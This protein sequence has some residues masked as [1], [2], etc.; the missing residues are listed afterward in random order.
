MRGLSI[1]GLA[2]NGLERIA[3]IARDLP[4]SLISGNMQMEGYTTSFEVLLGTAERATARMQY[5]KTFAAKTPFELPEVVAGSITLQSLTNG[6]LAEGAGLRMVGNVAAQ[7]KLVSPDTD[8]Q[9]TANLVGRI[10]GGIKAGGSNIAME[11]QRLT[12]LGVLSGETKRKIM[13]AAERGDTSPEQMWK[14]VQEDF[15]KLNGMMEK[16]ALTLSGRLS[17]VKDNIG[18]LRRN[19]GQG[20]FE[21]AKPLVSS[22]M[23]LTG[24]EGAQSTATR[25]GNALGGKLKEGLAFISQPSVVSGIKE[26]A[27][28][29]ATLAGN[30]LQK[31]KDIGGSLYDNILRPV[32]GIFR[33]PATAAG[34]RGTLAALGGLG[35]GLITGSFEKA[36][37]IVTGLFRWL[38]G[39][40]VQA[41]I[42]AVGSALKTG[43]VAG[44]DA[45]T[46]SA[47]WVWQNVLQPAYE[48]FT[49]PDV[50]SA[51]LD[52][53]AA[54]WSTLTSIGTTIWTDAIQPFG[55]WIGDP[56]NATLLG[57][58]AG[59]IG[60][61]LATGLGL[62]ADNIGPLVAGFVAWKL[63]E[64]AF[65]VA[66]LAKHMWDL[67]RG[68]G[69]AR[70]AGAGGAAIDGAAAAGGTLAAVG[71]VGAVAA[72]GAAIIGFPLIVSG[73]KEK[74]DKET[75]E[76]SDS[77]WRRAAES[78]ERSWAD[79]RDATVNLAPAQKILLFGLDKALMSNEDFGHYLGS[80]RQE[81]VALIQAE[82]DKL[83]A[84]L[85]LLSTHDSHD[86]ARNI[87]FSTPRVAPEGIDDLRRSRSAIEAE[88]R[89]AAQ[90]AKATI[91]GTV[92]EAPIDTSDLSKVPI[93]ADKAKDKAKKA[94]SAIEEAGSQVRAMAGA[95]GDW[96]KA[97]TSL[98]TFKPPANLR[99]KL[100]LLV[101]DVDYTMMAFQKV[102]LK[103]SVNDKKGDLKSLDFLTD[104]LGAARAGVGLVSDTAQAYKQMEEMVRP[105]RQSVDAILADSEYIFNRQK[106]AAAK[107][108][109]EQMAVTKLYG[110]STS[111]VFQ[112]LSS[113]SQFT[114]GIQSQKEDVRG[115]I[116][117]LFT[118]ADEALR[119]FTQW[120]STWKEEN[121]ER[122]A[123][124]GKNV[125][126]V[127]GGINPAF[128]AVLSAQG[129]SLVS[130]YEIDDAM[131][132]FEH[133]LGRV[134]RVMDSSVF[135]QD[136]ARRAAAFSQ[137]A[138]GLF[139]T[140]KSGLDLAASMGDG[141]ESS[142]EFAMEKTGGAPYMGPSSS[143]ALGGYGGYAG[144]G[145]GGPSYTNCLIV[146]GSVVGQD[147]D[148]ERIIQRMRSQ[149]TGKHGAVIGAPAF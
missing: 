8:F 34:I 75:A 135:Q 148:I 91:L 9:Q 29:L 26:V 49:R 70:A 30:G 11:M 5:L 35:T 136:W 113:V 51:I 17:N 97:A 22:L 143:V 121:M 40:D 43:V 109:V 101:T 31:I 16:Q 13:A 119:I 87:P 3:R 137:G 67:S 73:A 114:A 69:A 103:S 28:G 105:T 115:Q 48:F 53:I 74:Y 117:L 27:G 38:S 42:L 85:R 130:D 54:G 15:D 64:T 19:F 95:V 98:S 76:A 81:Y 116:R 90:A 68:I 32:F 72:A 60:G 39:A 44:W 99:P 50:G 88:K 10:Y 45:I 83:A 111:S 144:G 125:G 129:A 140:V 145:S 131:T 110:E 123:R 89:S 94:R 138:G 1:F 65:G 58:I 96:I 126:E 128:Q 24:S 77:F 142:Y 52:G 47:T 146:N 66:T 59:T 14:W 82:R 23:D 80:K 147:P 20:A 63:V 102:A 55:A 21:V 78:N 106:D 37:P 120:S 104:W 57:T 100:D 18:Q 133:I 62:A 71:G 2:A 46:T 33:D 139:S 36:G 118:N 108:S 4:A 56:A 112:G 107:Y 41:G 86:A 149:Q 6:K 93:E 122:A 79:A 7:A 61:T 25:L 132:N 124:I 127:F 92:K 134:S 12:E 84:D 141:Q